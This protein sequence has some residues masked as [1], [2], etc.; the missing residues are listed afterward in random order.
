M[1]TVRQQLKHIGRLI[2]D[3]N[4]TCAEMRTEIHKAQRES[5][6]MLE[7]AST[8]T[9]QKQAVETKQQLLD[10]FNK[11]FIVSEEDLITL[12]SSAESVDDRFFQIMNRVKQI[13]KDCEVLLGTENQSLGMELMEQTSRHLDAAFKKLYTWIQREFKILDLED[14]HISSTIRRALRVLAER[15]ILFQNCL[16]FF[17]EAREHALSDAFYLALTESV[18]GGSTA[19]RPANPIELQ[20]HNLLRYV[21]D[22]LAWVHSTTVSEREALEGLFISDG[23]EIAREIQAG[24]DNAPWSRGEQ[25]ENKTGDDPPVYDGRRA[26]NNL[27]NRDLDGV[28]RVLKQRVEIA[29]RSN[30]DPL[31]VYR[32]FNLFKFYQDIFFRLVGAPSILGDAIAELQTSTFSHFERLLQDETSTVASETVPEDLSTPTFLGRALDHFRSFTNASPDLSGPE[33]S[34]LISAALVPFLGQCSEMAGAMSDTTSQNLFQLNY[35]SAVDTALRPILPHKHGFLEAARK[36]VAEL[37]EE[38]VDTQHSFLLRESG[39][40]QLLDAIRSVEADA[41][42]P[43]AFESLPLFNTEALSAS[44]AQLDD[45]L[46]S[47]L[48]DLLDNMKQLTDKGLAKE[49]AH[50]A[51]EKFCTDFEVVEAAVL[52]VD[53]DMQDSRSG[54]EGE[55]EE[56]EEEEEEVLLRDV[57]PRT[58]AEIRVLL[59]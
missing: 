21:G 37:R 49:I 4:R 48:M 42:D 26:L 15:P 36:K 19:T 31:L 59:S 51:A 28:S 34:K 44:A 8:L 16:G 41:S 32:A 38:L 52:R 33:T 43:T 14:P 47:A 20:T 5:R 45:F 17:A 50:E 57:Y 6:P 46:A 55:G 54:R 13:R 22:M 27:V 39:V 11:H 25:K 40:G 56:G 9:T 1:L 53:E 23:D 7:E 3:L 58:T 18:P 12:T 30:D 2:I 35:L 29:V 10:A 24:R